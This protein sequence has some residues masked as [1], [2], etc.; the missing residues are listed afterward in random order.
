VSAVVKRRIGVEDAEC[1]L[2]RLCRDEERLELPVL[3]ADG[4][5]WEPLT[6]VRDGVCMEG[7]RGVRSI[8]R[9][10]GP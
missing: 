5:D 7:A 1:G 9:V 8:D 10:D 3:G 4:V 6:K 2:S